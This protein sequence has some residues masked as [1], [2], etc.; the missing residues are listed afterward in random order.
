MPRSLLVCKPSFE[1]ASTSTTIVRAH[2]ELAS[3]I[4]K[5]PPSDT[6]GMLIDTGFTKK[7]LVEQ[8]EQYARDYYAEEVDLAEDNGPAVTF[9]DEHGCI[10]EAALD[11]NSMAR[12]FSSYSML[13]WPKA[14]GR[15]DER[16]GE[17]SIGGRIS[18]MIERVLASDE[19][20]DPL[21]SGADTDKE[22]WHT[23]D[24]GSSSSTPVL[25][26]REITT[27]KDQLVAAPAEPVTSRPRRCGLGDRNA[28][29]ERRKARFYDEVDYE[30]QEVDDFGVIRAGC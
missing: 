25:Q 11:D 26:L 10:L 13:K 4:D 3:E 20:M 29:A 28:L 27:S 2:E 5:L 12:P 8:D 9:V 23:A 14:W 19:A 16:F 22:D 1:T 15:L 21:D 30:E 6:T 7:L 24:P 18:I 17:G